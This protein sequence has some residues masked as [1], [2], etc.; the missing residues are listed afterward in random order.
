MKSICQTINGF[1]QHFLVSQATPK[2]PE[3]LV[4]LHGLG[5]SCLDWEYQYEDLAKD[6]SLLIPDIRG[7]GRSAAEGEFSI[8]QFAIDVI[9]L[10]K[11]LKIESYHLIGLSMG[12]AIA[13]QMALQDDP[14][15]KSLTIVNS[16]PSF[17]RTPFVWV[18]IKL[19][20]TILRLFGLKAVAP[21][22]AA[23]LFPDGQHPE[24]VE[25][26]IKRFNTNN[27]AAYLKSMSALINWDISDRLTEIQCRTLI[28][29]A[30][31]DYF[32]VASKKAYCKQIAK[33]KLK[34]IKNTHHAL[35]VEDPAAF[36]QAIIEFIEDI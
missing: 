23:G 20:Q 27:K 11:H 8:E 21:K 15:L 2:K 18:K 16:A 26:F 34:V 33:A 5:S 29:A 1:K 25:K 10:V 14:A 6:Y 28:L 24:L 12:G 32:S 30:E 7:H 31:N 19:R 17:A 4:L 35:P 13:F 22:I 3:T 36:N 9:A